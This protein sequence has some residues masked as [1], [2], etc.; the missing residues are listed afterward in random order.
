MSYNGISYNVP[1]WSVTIVQNN[2][3]L[4]NTATLSA[5]TQT[6]V[7]KIKTRPASVFSDRIRNGDTKVEYWW[8]PMGVWGNDT[9]KAT[10]PQELIALTRDSTEYVLI[11]VLITCVLVYICMRASVRSRGGCVRVCGCIICACVSN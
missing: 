7:N 9:L 11:H 10:L 1:P 3:V 4:F 2:T 5:S 6:R 8:E